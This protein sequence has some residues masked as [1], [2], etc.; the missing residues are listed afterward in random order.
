MSLALA[1][2]APLQL[3][4]VIPIKR[5]AAGATNPSQARDGWEPWL[6]TRPNHF[7]FRDSKETLCMAVC[8]MI[9]ASL[10][11]ATNASEI[12][13]AQHGK[14]GAPGGDGIVARSHGASRPGT[15]RSTAQESL[16]AIFGGGAL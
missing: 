2:E 14:R 3:E 5:Q 8:M 4:T 9:R 1:E 11:D 13:L 10:F 16:K 12:A 7:T 6:R 15:D